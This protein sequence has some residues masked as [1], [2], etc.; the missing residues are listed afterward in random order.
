MYALGYVAGDQYSQKE[1]MAE[2]AKMDNKL[3]IDIL[4]QLRHPL[5]IMSANADK[6]YDRKNQIIM[7]LILL[8]IVGAMGPVVAMLHPIQSMKFYL[9]TAHGDSKT[10]MGERGRDNPLQGLCQGN[11]TAFACWLIISS[12]LMHCYQRKGFGSWIILPISGAIIDFLGEIYVDDTNLIVTLPNLT[13]LKAV[14]E[15]LDD[16]ADAWSLSLNST[17]RAINP[18]KSQW[19]LA[20]YE[21][22]KSLWRYCTQPQTEMT[23]PLPDGTR[24]HIS[25]GNVSTAEKLLGVWSTIDRNDSKHIEENVTGKTQ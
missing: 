24:A 19:I 1:S 15:K 10:F 20:A 2:D 11:G 21:W 22:V 14:L 23:I 18:E 6:C 12:V 25:H 8:A 5:A 17:G 3:T 13:T 7:S 9:C 16:L 4:R